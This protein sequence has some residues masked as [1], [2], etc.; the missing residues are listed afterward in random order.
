MKWCKI[1]LIL[2]LTITLGGCKPQGDIYQRIN[3]T[4]MNLE[5]YYAKCSAKVTGNK[6]ENTYDFEVF[7]KDDGNIKI[8][9]N[10]NSIEID[11]QNDALTLKNPMIDH[12]ITLDGEGADYP[13]FII[14]T[15]FK[16]YFAGEEASIV[17]SG[18]PKGNY[19]ELECTIPSGNDYASSQKLYIDNDTLFPVS[20]KTFNSKGDTVI[21]VDFLEFSKD[22]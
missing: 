14:N 4:Y 12:T 21:D 8:I 2:T 7:S 1:I 6:T 18:F 19:T 5:S 13:N 20:L 22:K 16:N 10:P 17:V 11:I 3:S 15:F 9:F